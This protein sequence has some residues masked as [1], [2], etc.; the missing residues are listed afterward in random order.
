MTNPKTGKAALKR[1]KLKFLVK[2]LFYS[3]SSISAHFWKAKDKIFL[4][5]YPLT[6]NSTLYDPS[7]EVPLVTTPT[8]TILS[9]TSKD[10]NSMN[11]SNP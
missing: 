7:A 10:F 3:L 9:K 8:E 1:E 6:L 5:V 2:V 11:S 4:T